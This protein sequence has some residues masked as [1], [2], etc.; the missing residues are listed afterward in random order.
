MRKNYA[1]SR[2][3]ERAVVKLPQTRVA[4]T[5]IGAISTKGVIHIALRKPPPPPAKDTKKRARDNKGKKR[6]VT[7]VEEEADTTTSDYS[8]KPPPKGT[9]SAHYTKFIN[10]L[11][12]ILEFWSLVILQLETI[13]S[14][15]K[16]ACEQ[17]LLSDLY[18][19][20]NHSKRQISKCYD[21]IPF[22]K[23]LSSGRLRM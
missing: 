1:W 9:T 3:S 18:G 13:S 8:Q 15:I 10:E 7:A 21:R 20:A 4:H 19:F 17:V 22:Q 12:D 14:R 11:L 23:A 2:K 6:A 5:I 16:D